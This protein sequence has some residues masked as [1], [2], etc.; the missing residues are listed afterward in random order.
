MLWPCSG[1]G[2]QRIVCYRTEQGGSRMVQRR[3]EFDLAIFS[4]YSIAP[5][6]AE[7]D[8]ADRNPMN[9]PW[10]LNV[11]ILQSFLPPLNDPA[12]PFQAPRKGTPEQFA[13]LQGTYRQYTPTVMLMPSIHASEH[14]SNCL[15]IFALR[16][17]EH[18]VT[19]IATASQPQT[20]IH[21]RSDKV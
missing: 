19:D 16:Q 2:C 21:D 13:I 9:V 7:H 3:Q 10:S 14:V 18:W 15:P 12:P 4:R 17:Y 8:D 1:L 11:S 6:L 20:V 5:L